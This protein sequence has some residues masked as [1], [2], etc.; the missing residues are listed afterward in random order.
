MVDNLGQRAADYAD[1][2]SGFRRARTERFTLQ[3][4]R[5]QTE[6]MRRRAEAA[7]RQA[8]LEAQRGDARAGMLTSTAVV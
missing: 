3:Q 7:Q 8:E 6:E 2:Q 5:M 4:Q 1:F